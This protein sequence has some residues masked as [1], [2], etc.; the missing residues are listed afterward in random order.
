M[1]YLQRSDVSK[2]EKH[3]EEYFVSQLRVCGNHW[4][5][6]CEGFAD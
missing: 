4:L 2:K 1:Q 6:K 5:G 3:P